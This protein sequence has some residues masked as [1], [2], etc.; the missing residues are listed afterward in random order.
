MS[1]LRSAAPVRTAA[2]TAQAPSVQAGLLGAGARGLATAAL[3]PGGSGRDTKNSQLFVSCTYTHTH[4]CTHSYHCTPWT[5]CCYSCCYCFS[6][7]PKVLHCGASASWLRSAQ[8]LEVDGTNESPECTQTKA[9]FENLPLT[10]CVVRG[11]TKD[12]DS[13][14]ARLVDAKDKKNWGE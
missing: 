14:R 3:R 6:L 12:T 2:T 7:R 13:P 5:I 8:D 1:V 4:K 10:T 11:N 9:W